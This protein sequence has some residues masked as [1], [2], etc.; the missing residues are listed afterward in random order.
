MSTHTKLFPVACLLVEKQQT[1]NCTEVNAEAYL[2]CLSGN[3]GSWPPKCVCLC[4][5]MC[6]CV[7]VCVCSVC[8]NSCESV[9]WF[10]HTLVLFL[11]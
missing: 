1:L 9:S 6:M 4:V 10:I 3:R 5:S 7:T 11:P 2:V 8:V